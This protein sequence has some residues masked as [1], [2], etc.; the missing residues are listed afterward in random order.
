MA[1]A[2]QGLLDCGHVGEFAS[3]CQYESCAKRLCPDCGRLCE[4]C[5]TVLCPTHQVRVDARQRVFC[6]RHSLNYVARKL[7]GK[8][9]FGGMTAHGR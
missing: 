9:L 2:A 4:T 7:A 8:L 6:P 3:V 1:G 5:G